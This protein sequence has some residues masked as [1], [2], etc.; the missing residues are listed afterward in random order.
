MFFL[1]GA[2]FR[3]P[4]IVA[5]VYTFFL[6]S[7]LGNLPGYL[8]RASINFYTQCMMYDAL[9]VHNIRHP[10]PDIYMPVDGPTACLVL[11]G[12]TLFFL[13]LGMLWFARKEY[14]EIS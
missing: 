12:A 2:F 9:E 11:L 5:I 7:I 4:A 1:I 10:R 6:E 8:K 3:R 13:A 14:H